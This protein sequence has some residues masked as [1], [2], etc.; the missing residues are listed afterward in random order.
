MVRLS[1]LVSWWAEASCPLVHGCVAK[2]AFRNGDWDLPSGVYAQ[3]IVPRDPEPTRPAQ[4]ESQS[5][6]QLNQPSPSQLPNQ[7]TQTRLSTACKEAKQPVSRPSGGDSRFLIMVTGFLIGI[8][9]HAVNTQQRASQ[10]AHR[11]GDRCEM[12]NRACDY[13][14]GVTKC[15]QVVFEWA[16]GRA[17]TQIRSRETERCKSLEQTSN[18]AI[19]C[20]SSLCLGPLFQGALLKVGSVA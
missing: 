2:S 14:C 12:P 5:V 15:L 11:Q 3:N 8:Y 4:G 20:S 17:G 9:W 6:N 10:P 19:A 7:P 16:A 1:S 18:F 13:S